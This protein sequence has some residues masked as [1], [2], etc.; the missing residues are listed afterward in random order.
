MPNYG[1][2]QAGGVL[3]SVPVGEKF[4][5]FNA[6]SVTA[7]QASVAFNRAPSPSGA[8]Q[9]ITFTID[10]ASSPTASVTIQGSNTDV[11]ADYLV[12]ATSSNKQHDSY[13]DTGRFAYYR[14]NVAS[15]SGGGAITVK[16]QR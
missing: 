6:E 10:F 16:A 2:A 13:T 12:L 11:D 5:L 4:T 3:T 1:V 15:Q 14:A 9:G 8:D 7:P